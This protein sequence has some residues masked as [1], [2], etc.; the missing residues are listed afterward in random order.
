[1][2]NKLIAAL[3]TIAVVFVL[4]VPAAHADNVDFQCGVGAPGACTG[5]VTSSDNVNFSTTGI[6]VFNDSGQ[7]DSS[8][9]FTL[10]FDTSTG[11]VS[12]SG[13]GALVGQDLSGTIY[14]YSL[15]CGN[16]TCDASFYA[17]WDT[18][19][20]AVQTALGTATGTDSGFAI[21]LKSDGANGAAQSVDV[22]IT[23]VPEPASLV[24]FGSGLLGMAGFLRRKLFG[25]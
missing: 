22:L 5:T 15:N 3:A 23:P 9:P 17:N 1:M 16:T 24:L 4:G 12:I 21:Y 13:T 8:V 7:Y 6:S 14:D 2:R 19:P 18:L 10:A 20:T 11:T 25:A